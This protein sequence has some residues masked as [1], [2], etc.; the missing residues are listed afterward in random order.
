MQRQAQR[1]MEDLQAFQV[2]LHTIKTD[3]GD[4]STAK[5]CSA[6]LP[7]E[8]RAQAAAGARQWQDTLQEP[9]TWC[10]P[11]QLCRLLGLLCCPGQASFGVSRAFRRQPE[12]ARLRGREL[13]TPGGNT[14]AWRLHE[15][16]SYHALPLL[17]PLAWLFCL[18]PLPPA[19]SK[20]VVV[21]SSLPGQGHLFRPA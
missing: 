17:I 8:R 19:T 11:K 12:D 2:A 15:E 6:M 10:V 13:H 4:P 9:Q 1:Q 18:E 20:A 5:E 3:W 7:Q 21:A 16:R 14:D